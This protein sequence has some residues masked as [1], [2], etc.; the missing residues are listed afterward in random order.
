MNPLFQQFVS[1][2]ELLSSFVPL[3]RT[4]IVASSSANFLLGYTGLYTCLLEWILRMTSAHPCWG[5]LFFMA[6]PS[7][8]ISNGILPVIILEEILPKQHGTC[9]GLQKKQ[10]FVIQ[11]NKMGQ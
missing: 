8:K 4:D 7:Y 2:W 10:N 6:A 5:L 9:V 11:Y 3:D 1:V